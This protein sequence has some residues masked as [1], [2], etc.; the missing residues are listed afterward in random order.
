MINSVRHSGPDQ[1]GGPPRVATGVNVKASIRFYLS[2]SRFTLTQRH[3]EQLEDSGTDLIRWL[4]EN[5]PKIGDVPECIGFMNWDKH[6]EKFYIQEANG[7]DV[8]Y[9][10]AGFEK[11]DY[12]PDPVKFP[13]DSVDAIIYFHSMTPYELGTDFADA[14]AV[15]DWEPFNGTQYGRYVLR[16]ER[17]DY[18]SDLSKFADQVRSGVARP[19]RVWRLQ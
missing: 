6:R 7:R 15:L 17:M 2:R 8:H 4:R 19:K 13:I 14:Q 11:P 1:I 10:P 9:G 18:L 3:K 5:G 12:L 16:V